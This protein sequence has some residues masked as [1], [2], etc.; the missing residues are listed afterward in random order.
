[1]SSSVLI[2]RTFSFG[3][4]KERPTETGKC[5]IYL[6][7]NE[8][9]IQAQKFPP[10]RANTSPDD[11]INNSHGEPHFEDIRKVY[12]TSCSHKTSE[13][14]IISATMLSFNMTYVHNKRK[15]RI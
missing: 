2:G 6:H 1:V 13:K 14:S 4:E 11:S 5:A 9:S 12:I 10:Q 8:K 7:G 3:R 15:E